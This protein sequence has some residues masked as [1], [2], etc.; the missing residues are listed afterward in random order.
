MRPTSRPSRSRRFRP[1]AVLSVAVVAVLAGAC[2][3]S[4][5]NGASGAPSTIAPGSPWQGSLVTVTLPP[6]VNSLDALDCVDAARCWAVG[7]TVGAAGSP[8]GAA[9][10][11]TTNGGSTWSLQPIPATVA[12]LSGISCSD[13]RHCAAVGQTANGPGA[14]LTTADGGATWQAA[15]VPPGVLDVTAVACL[16]DRRCL[17]T[18]STAS[19]TAALVSTSAQAGWVQRGT[20]PPAL[21]G[22]TGISC[23]D[24]QQC[25]VTVH[26]SLD[27]DHVAGAVAVT[28]DGGATWAATAP[29]AGVGYLN[30]IVC[31]PHR[32]GGLPFTSTTV[33]SS[34]ASTTTPPGATPSGT[35]PASTTSPPT[36]SPPTT[37]PPA[38]S[39]T[40][41]PAGVAGV[42]CVAV[43]TTAN[44]LTGVRTGRG[45]ILT[46]ANGGATWSSQPVTP[47]AAALMG[48][49]CTAVDSCVAVGSS[50]ALSSHAGVAVLTASAGH[51]WRSAAAVASPQELTAA[52]CLSLSQCVLVGESIGE[53]LAGS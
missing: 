4:P 21:S 36:T 47:S 37:S 49:S 34:A 10:V 1:A 20:L 19:G 29:P 45:V 43:G 32:G 50:V 40:A 33:P 44:T 41:P 38:V 28:T 24:N 5:S 46:S 8:N 48:V 22:A 9:V 3:A 2:S 7:S 16:A 12:Y 13:R 17:A 27:V 26:S 25:W 39:T 23:P 31:T 51:P 14:I 6:P 42:W 30:A 35:A 11:A 53:H 15:A 52:S 18:G